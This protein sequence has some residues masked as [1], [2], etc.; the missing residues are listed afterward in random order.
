MNVGKFVVLGSGSLP[1]RTSSTL[2]QD[3]IEQSVSVCVCVCARSCLL[4][5]R[6]EAKNIATC[7]TGSCCRF[8]SL[9]SAAAAARKYN[10]VFMLLL[11]LLG[12][13]CVPSAPLGTRVY[14][15]SPIIHSR[16]ADHRKLK[17][18]ALSYT[19]SS[20]SDR[21]LVMLARSRYIQ[22]AKHSKTHTPRKIKF[23]PQP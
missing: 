19:R 9:R 10:A 4:K 8:L 23:T 11:L 18:I 20:L 5:K 2:N 17:I 7:K 16:R 14:A 12:K 3:N 13:I 6:H 21:S 22:M 1:R 15:R